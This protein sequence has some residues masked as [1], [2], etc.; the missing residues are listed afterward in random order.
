MSA[1]SDF[2]AVIRRAERAA[3]KVEHSRK[4]MW[5]IAPNGARVLASVSPSD[6]NAVHN[7]RRDLERAG[8]E[9]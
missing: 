7:L 6:V 1:G 2:K 3:C 9:L 4:H 5:I 8:V